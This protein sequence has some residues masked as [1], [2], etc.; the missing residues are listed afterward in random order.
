MMEY[1][2]FLFMNRF[3]SLSLIFEK[4]NLLNS[5]HNLLF[6]K[7]SFIVGYTNYQNQTLYSWVPNLPTVFDLILIF[8][9][10]FFVSYNLDILFHFVNNVYQFIKE[11]YFY[12]DKEKVWRWI[13]ISKL[14]HILNKYFKLM[15]YLFCLFVHYHYYLNENF[16]FFGNL[17]KIVVQQI[18]YY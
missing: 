13:S 10:F 2:K 11:F 6:N 7:L 15:A 1:F 17:V 9:C 12:Y 4:N 14:E 5:S 16:W 8:F 18:R 3:F